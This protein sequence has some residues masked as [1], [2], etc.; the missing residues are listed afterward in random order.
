M[1]S[2]SNVNKNYT[3]EI[4]WYDDKGNLTGFF[5]NEFGFRSIYIKYR[6]NEF[7]F[8]RLVCDH[9]NFTALTG[10]QDYHIQIVVKGTYYIDFDMA[11]T[12]FS[13][14]NDTCT[15]EGLMCRSDKILEVGSEFLGSD[16]VSAIKKLGFSQVFDYNKT[17]SGKFY[18]INS[19]KLV[20]LIKLLSGVAQNSSF[21][22]TDDEI[23]IIN[24]NDTE[25]Y[26]MSLD[27]KLLTI[28][29]SDTYSRM[30]VLNNHTE[31]YGIAEI[32]NN[33]IYFRRNPEYYKNIM[34]NCKFMDGMD[35]TSHQ[36]YNQFIPVTPGK[37]IPLKLNNT[38]VDKFIVIGKE[39]FFSDGFKTILEIGT[40]KNAFE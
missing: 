24:M 9:L 6:L 2:V 17:F 31:H 32:Y 26:E 40:Y 18:R 19:N 16:I 8:I 39:M 10:I 20:S 37:R 13:E 3:I 12:N 36:E 33:R 22:I 5:G 38:I 34:T 29:Y 4:K 27:N 21:I 14:S 25:L 1:S 15:I 23:K 35:L 7:P 11:M 30:D 28:N